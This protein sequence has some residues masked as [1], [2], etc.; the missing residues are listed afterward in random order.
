MNF[1]LLIHVNKHFHDDNES[2]DTETQNSLRLVKIGKR[3]I[4]KIIKKEF[5]DFVNSYFVN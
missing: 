5:Y 1:Y 4:K 3:L 2:P